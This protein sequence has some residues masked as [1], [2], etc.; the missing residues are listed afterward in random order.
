MIDVA[1]SKLSDAHFMG[2][3]LAS[4]GFAATVV[5]ALLPLIQTNNLNRRIKA[6]SS[7]RERIRLRERERLATAQEQDPSAP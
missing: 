3:L 4:I 5:M 2:V 6:V 1:I 7:E